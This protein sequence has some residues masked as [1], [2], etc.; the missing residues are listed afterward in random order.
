MKSLIL[1][2]PL[3]VCGAAAAQDLSL[4]DTSRQLRAETRAAAGAGDWEAARRTNEA[5]LALQPG[6]AGLLNNAL[7]I[8]GFAGDV[9]GQFLALERIAGAGL[10][11]DISDY[12]RAD[13][14]RT[15][16]PERL[17]ALEAAFAAIAAPAG[18]A[19]RVA[20][21]PL[22]DALIEA[23]AVDSETERLFLGSV[24]DR[25]IYRVEPFAPEAFEVFA[26]ED[27]P[28]GSIFGLAVD[29]RHGRL[30]AAEGQIEGIT[31]AAEGEALSTA[32][33]AFDLE[34]GALIER[35]TIE[36]A[37]RIGDVA[38]RDGV[39]LA[40][41]AEAGRIYRLNGP[42]A[43]LELYA[44][45]PRFESLQGVVSTRGAVFAVDYAL[46]LWRI[47]P[48]E[49]SAVLMPTPPGASLIGLDGMAVDRTGRV[50]VIRNGAAP[51][52]VFELEFDIDNQLTAMRPVLTGD[53]RLG[54]PVT[55]RLTDGRAFLINDAQWPL[56]EGEGADPDARTD[57]LI[58]SVPLP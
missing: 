18:D 47:D 31:P 49:R 13:T 26:G 30:Y 52:G 48:V 58:L 3:L 41:D 24:A 51:V 5:A 34:T 7:L 22:K 27:E 28:V 4:L 2:L 6:H 15:A 25:R 53:D 8:A 44:E 33:L 10:A 29:R 17:A 37:E 56:F 23:L 45:D 50:F 39:V 55:V 19:R 14:L 20:E 54:E 42:R 9:E 1:T 32:L 11:F 38:V 12:G 21:P 35:Y 40:T 43:Q 36:G 57:P 46:G 16:D